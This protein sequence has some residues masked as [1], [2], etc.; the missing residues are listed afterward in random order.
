MSLSE[1]RITVIFR[2]QVPEELW[3]YLAVT[4]GVR[5]AGRRPLVVRTDRPEA[6]LNGMARFLASPAMK[7]SRVLVR[8]AGTVPMSRPVVGPEALARAAG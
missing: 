3:D 5:V 1:G 4:P 8:P 7:V 2:G 6:V